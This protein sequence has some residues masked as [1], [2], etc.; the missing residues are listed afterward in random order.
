MPARS[1]AMAYELDISEP[2]EGEVRRIAREQV[3]RA[4]AELGGDDAARAVH[5]SRKRMKRLRSLLRALRPLLGRTY[6]TENVRF[7]DIARRLAG[8]RDARVLADTAAALTAHAGE[9]AAAVRPVAQAFAERYRS[10]VAAGGEDGASDAAAAELDA[11]RTA[12]DAWPLG[13]LDRRALID[14]LARVYAAGR[15]ARDHAGNGADAEANHEWRKHAQRHWHHM[16]LVRRLWPEAMAAREAA[17]KRLVDLLGRDHDLSALAA[18]LA[19]TGTKGAAAMLE[20]LRE[21]QRLIRAEVGFV[22]RRL[23]AERP[24]ALA[25]RLTAYWRAAEREANGAGPKAR[26]RSAQ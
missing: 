25:S 16:R 9:R 15:R 10:L 23:Y 21:R 11:A 1:S 19:G 3:A 5:E 12:I 7:R 6:E 14:G 20:L 2:L 17:A 26:R 13:R 8:A 4:L 24:A 22:A 18:A